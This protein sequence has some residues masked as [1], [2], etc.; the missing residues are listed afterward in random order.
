VPENQRSLQRRRDWWILRYGCLLTL[1]VA[2][3]GCLFF[4]AFV[5]AMTFVNGPWV[6]LL[7][8]CL[9]TATAIPYGV[10]LIW[11]DRNGRNPLYLIGTGF[12]WGAVVATAISLVVNTTVGL[13]ASGYIADPQLAEQITASLSAPFIEELT[14]GLAV[15]FIFLLFRRHFDHVLDGMIYGAVVGL[16]FAWLENIMYY[17]NSAGSG[18]AE[19]MLKLS[20]LRGVLNGLSSHVCYT[21]LT[22]MGFGIFRILRKGVLRWLFIPGFWGLGMFAHFMWNT[23]VGPVV[24]IVGVESDRE[25][26]LVGLPVA[27]VV[28]QSPFMGLLAFSGMLSWLHEN[29]VVRRE[30]A[31]EPPQ[32]VHPDEI[33]RLVPARKRIFFSFLRFF[34]RGPV[35]WWHHRV[36]DKLLIKLAFERWHVRS[37]PSVTWSP[38]EDADIYEL[39]LRIMERR[40][41]LA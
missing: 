3:A 21:G 15:L 11:T 40:R 19:S 22:G 38:D 9:A 29:R 24:G 28:L 12:L 34:L 18:G 1:L 17:V 35:H 27:I 41:Q 13:V 23:F 39:R 30:L 37:D 6:F 10:F 7:A 36:L 2:F 8:V 32:V 14:K 16:G 31:D 26:L 33:K 20:Y 4:S 25:L 5:N